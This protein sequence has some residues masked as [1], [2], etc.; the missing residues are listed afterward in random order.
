MSLRQC[1]ILIDISSIHHHYLI[2][3]IYFM[4]FQCLSKY[5]GC[6]WPTNPPSIN[7]GSFI[8][9]KSRKHNVFL[10]ISFLIWDD[11]LSEVFFFRLVELYVHLLYLWW[12]LSVFNNKTM[13]ADD[14]NRQN[15]KDKSIWKKKMNNKV[16]ILVD[17][18]APNTE[19]F[20]NKVVVEMPK[21]KD[22]INRK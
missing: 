16:G 19:N 8:V 13:L 3:S 1:Q 14:R 15:R 5:H 10:S 4:N 6:C 20:K 11:R 22:E 17:L 12:L 21:K 18:L 9:R 2:L 7:F